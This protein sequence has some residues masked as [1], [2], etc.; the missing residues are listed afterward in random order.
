MGGGHHQGGRGR[1]RKKKPVGIETLLGHAIGC[2]GM[3]LDDFCRLTPSEFEAVCR[4]W[5]EREESL[6]RDGWERMRMGA[7]IGIQP[8]VKEKVTPQKMLP[9]PWERPKRDAPKVSAEE[10]R[11]RYEKLMR[12][13]DHGKDD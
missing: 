8:H 12:T 7:A 13:I 1:R 4:S 3:R 2:V 11:K 5:N 10:A 9:F 6:V